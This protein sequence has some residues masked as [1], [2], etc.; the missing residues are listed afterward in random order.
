MVNPDENISADLKCDNDASPD[1]FFYKMSS[2][3]LFQLVL[4]SKLLDKID[5]YPSET[6]S[7]LHRVLK[8]QYIDL[9]QLKA[10]TNSVG[11]QITKTFLNMPKCP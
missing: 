6:S 9:Y 5:V 10:L 3:D 2:Q 1:D 4:M 7:A 11:C 8:L